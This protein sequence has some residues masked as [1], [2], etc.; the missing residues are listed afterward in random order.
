VWVQRSLGLSGVDWRNGDGDNYYAASAEVRDLF[1]A[2]SSMVFLICPPMSKSAPSSYFFLVD[3]RCSKHQ[4]AEF[5]SLM[6]LPLVN[7][8]FISFV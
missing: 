8:L 2:G 5:I 3:F 4:K 6:A 7:I 1:I